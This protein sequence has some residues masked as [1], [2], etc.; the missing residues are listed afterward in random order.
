MYAAE[1]IGRHTSP[2]LV[3]TY[4][5]DCATYVYYLNFFPY[6][7]NHNVMLSDKLDTSRVETL[8]LLFSLQPRKFACC[9]SNISKMEADV[10]G[11][12][13]AFLLF[14]EHYTLPSRS[15]TEHISAV[16]FLIF[17]IWWSIDWDLWVGAEGIA[18]W[19][20]EI[21]FIV[22]QPIELDVRMQKAV[23][24]EAIFE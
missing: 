14:L 1:L 12:L 5:T 3:W 24:D 11:G 22:C 8:L 20:K 17:V 21:V 2:P 4:I 16:S 18:A 15:N 9:S 10:V 19:D 7:V 23:F 13:L 6:Y